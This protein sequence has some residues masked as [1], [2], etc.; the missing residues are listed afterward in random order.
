M[1]M[2]IIFIIIIITIIIIFVSLLMLICGGTPGRGTKCGHNLSAV[3]SKT[4]DA[5]VMNNGSERPQ[6]PN[7]LPMR[8]TIPPCITNRALIHHT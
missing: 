4:G 6:S 5:A 8:T 3:H 7:T 2:F 1:A